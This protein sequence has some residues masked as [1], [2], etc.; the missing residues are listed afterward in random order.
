VRPGTLIVIIVLLIAMVAF[1]FFLLRQV[2]GPPS[3]VIPT[4][5]VI[6]AT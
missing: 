6:V 2:D 4:P 5:T 3:S 1:S